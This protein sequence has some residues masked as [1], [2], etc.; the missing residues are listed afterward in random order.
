M[1]IRI[2]KAWLGAR[3]GVHWDK[4]LS[5]RWPSPSPEKKLIFFARDG[6]LVNFQR[7]FLENLGDNLCID[8]LVGMV[9]VS[10]SPRSSLLAPAHPEK[11]L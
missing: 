6:I 3:N 8:R 9:S 10:A 4:G 2:Q 11:G 7:Y 5:G 1:Q